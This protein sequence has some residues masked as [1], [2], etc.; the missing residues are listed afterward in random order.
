MKFNKL[1]LL[2]G[3]LSL[4]NGVLTFITGSLSKKQSRFEMKEEVAKVVADALSKKGS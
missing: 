4:L 2:L 1:S 3:G